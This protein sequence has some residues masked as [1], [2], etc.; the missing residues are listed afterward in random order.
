MGDWRSIYERFTVLVDRLV[1]AWAG[2]CW[3]M[4]LFIGL[5]VFFV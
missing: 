1:D 5:V 4:L 2:V 3:I